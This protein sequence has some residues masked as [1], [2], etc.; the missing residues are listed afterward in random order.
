MTSNPEGTEWSERKQT[1]YFEEDTI[2]SV[3]SG[4]TRKPASPSTSIL[5]EKGLT[6][7]R[8]CT[9]WKAMISA[10]PGR[11]RRAGA[12]TP[13][14]S[15]DNLLWYWSTKARTATATSRTRSSIPRT[16]DHPVRTEQGIPVRPGQRSREWRTVR[17]TGTEGRNALPA[18][19]RATITTG[20]GNESDTTWRI[21]GPPVGPQPYNPWRDRNG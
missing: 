19:S 1:A 11:R 5:K 3:G 9:T 10:R 15:K 20:P 2:R 13:L 18:S 16:S 17:W 4:R 14:V 8:T 12:W 6:G 7:A 21:I